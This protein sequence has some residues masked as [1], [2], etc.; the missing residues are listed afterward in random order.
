MAAV[1]VKRS[2]LYANTK[3]YK[4]GFRT[5]DLCTFCDNQPE[6]LTHLFY[7][8]SRSKQFWI[9]F[10]LYWCQRI[11][12]CLENACDPWN[13]DGKCLPFTSFAELFYNYWKKLFVGLLEQTNPSKHLWIQGELAKYKTEGKNQQQRILENK[14]DTDALFKLTVLT[15][16]YFIALLYFFSNFFQPCNIL[17]INF[18]LLCLYLLLKCFLVVL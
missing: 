14:V 8:C 9:E 10:E 5:N 18:A 11:R 4:I 2:I 3:L 7:H 17:T 6:S 1:S 15:P 13:F 12:L 16:Y